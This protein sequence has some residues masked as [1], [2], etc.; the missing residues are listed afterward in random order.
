[1]ARFVNVFGFFALCCLATVCTTSLATD[2][3]NGRIELNEEHVGRPPEG[4]LLWRTGTGELG[5]WRVVKD[6]T[7]PAGLAIEHSSRDH[8]EDRYSLAVH[9]PVFA[10]SYEVSARIRIISGRMQSAGV[11]LR[12]RNEL[13][14]YLV[15]INAL[16]ERVD[17]FRVIQGQPR[18]L[19]GVETP[20]TRGKWHRI[21]VLMVKDQIAVAVDSGAM[22]RVRD[23]TFLN[24]GHVALWT[25]EDN[26]TRFDGI[27]IVPL[28]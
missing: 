15:R 14:Y 23:R 10:E 20:I 17:V 1:M 5:N 18:R 8:T 16:E 21:D 9:A 11:A 19:T 6:A 22:L 3:P 4:F 27:S 13:N 12:V 7:A 25:E 24:A 2:L 26:V 28:Q